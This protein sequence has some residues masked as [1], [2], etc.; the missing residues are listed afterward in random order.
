MTEMETL[1]AKLEIAER[2]LEDTLGSDYRE[3]LH[4]AGLC[5]KHPSYCTVCYEEWRKTYDN[6]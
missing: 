5:D 1:M 4:N 3:E 6:E 2:L